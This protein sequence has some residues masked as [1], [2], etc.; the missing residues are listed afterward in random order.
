MYGCVVSPVVCCWWMIRKI[1]YQ[2]P[3]YPG[4]YRQSYHTRRDDWHCSWKDLQV[5]D[6]AFDALQLVGTLWKRSPIEMYWLFPLHFC[7]T[8]ES[9]VAQCKEAGWGSPHTLLRFVYKNLDK[10]YSSQD[11]ILTNSPCFKFS[12]SELVTSSPA[13]DENDREVPKGGTEG[14]HLLAVWFRKFEWNISRIG[15]SRKKNG[16]VLCTKK[17]FE[18]ICKM[19]TIYMKKHENIK[20]HQD[21]KIEYPQRFMQRM[22]LFVFWM[23]LSVWVCCFACLISRCCIIHLANLQVLLLGQSCRCWILPVRAQQNSHAFGGWWKPQL[24]PG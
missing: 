21:F 14:E 16:C 8:P 1:R 7:L 23:F 11:Q 9:R 6:Y 20:N 3:W 22:F 5:P 18:K 2:I 17:I 19:Y 15:L 10:P 4:N 13:G 24:G 12:P